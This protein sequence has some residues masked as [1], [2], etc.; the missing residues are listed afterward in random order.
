MYDWDLRRIGLVIDYALAPLIQFSG[1]QAAWNELL[2]QGICQASAALCTGNLQQY[3][4]Q[5]NCETF[6]RALPVGNYD[7][8][9]QDNLT[10]RSLHA[11]LVPLRPAV[12]CSHIG[13]TGGGKCV[14][15]PPQ[16]L[17]TDDFLVCSS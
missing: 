12:H 5:T 9:D 4:N 15:P 3:A 10:C 16:P 13:K 17:F 1:G 11:M 7:S 8:A 2:I 6:L 14:V